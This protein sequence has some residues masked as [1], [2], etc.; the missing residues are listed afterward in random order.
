MH[1]LNLAWHGAA[2]TLAADLVQCGDDTAALVGGGWVTEADLGNAPRV[3]AAPGAITYE[4]LDETD[5]GDVV[6]RLARSR[7][8]D[9]AVSAYADSDIRENFTS[10]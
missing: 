6:A 1:I 8:A 2:M 7:A 4:P 9:A 3:G 5:A 10:R